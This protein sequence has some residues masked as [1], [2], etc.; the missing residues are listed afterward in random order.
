MESTKY[1]G[2]TIVALAAVILQI[3]ALLLVIALTAGQDVVK[4]VL[5]PGTSLEEFRTVP[6]GAILKT[7]VML[8]FYL[9]FMGLSFAKQKDNMSK[10]IAVT[11][12][13]CVC[14]ID[15]LLGFVVGR[16]EN[17]I[18]ASKGGVEALASLS[19]LNNAISFVSGPLTVVAFALF[20]MA[21]G[22][23]MNE[24]NDAI[25]KIPEL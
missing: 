17:V 2:R 4:T 20:C 3:C 6:V 15:I 5:S 12:F 18:V 14:V 22:M 7:V 10:G 16:I 25:E 11:L 24:K 9:A 23:C 8:I 1:K 13:I 19:V 21:I